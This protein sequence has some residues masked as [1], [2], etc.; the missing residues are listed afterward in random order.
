M[1]SNTSFIDIMLYLLSKLA[2]LFTAAFF[3]YLPECAPP[4][5]PEHLEVVE[6]DVR[7]RRA[8]QLGDQLA[9]PLPHRRR[10][11]EQRRR[12]KRRR[13]SSPGRAG[14]KEGEGEGEGGLEYRREKS[15]RTVNR[16]L[17]SSLAPKL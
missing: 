1:A 9:V 2:F 4:D 17:A 10:Q 8:A 5:G 13:R 3:P 15:A 6:V 7:G 11:Q 14:R 16:F 12:L